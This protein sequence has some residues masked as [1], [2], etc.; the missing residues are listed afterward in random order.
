MTIYAYDPVDFKVNYNKTYI[1][2]KNGLMYSKEFK[3]KNY[4]FL[5]TRTNK[6][7]NTT[8]VFIIFTN[9]IP[10]NNSKFYR[11]NKDEYGRVK[12]PVQ[13][14]ISGIP[15]ERNMMNVDISID[16]EDDDNIAYKILEY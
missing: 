11:I 10:N 16:D 14:V 12:I 5:A 8:E 9:D 1:N 4:A 3:I 7:R 15:H 13:S 6:E 2:F